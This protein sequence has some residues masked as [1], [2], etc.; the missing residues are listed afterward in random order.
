M[1]PNPDRLISW[2]VGLYHVGKTRQD[3]IGVVKIRLIELRKHLLADKD[4]EYDDEQ[5]EDEATDR[6]AKDQCELVF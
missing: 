3:V 2:S 5:E 6:T 4:E 1:R